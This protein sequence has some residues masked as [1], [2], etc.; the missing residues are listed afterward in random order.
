[1]AIKTIT[2]RMGAS[3]ECNLFLVPPQAPATLV[4]PFGVTVTVVP[5]VAGCP[6]PSN[7]VTND[8]TGPGNP[9][10]QRQASGRTVFIPL[11]PTSPGHASGAVS[12]GE[13]AGGAYTPQPVTLEISISKCPGI[14]DTDTRNFCNLRSTN[15][16]YNAIT[17]LAQAYQNINSG[18]AAQNGYCWAGDGGQYYINAR[19]TYASCASGV[20]ICGF[21]IVYNIGPF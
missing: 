19:W 1:M 18:N 21:A 3:G 6:M 11:P 12:F 9:V 17:Y 2:V 20:E 15:G 13:S 8:L 7:V 14:I 10:F 4:A 5:A 16:F